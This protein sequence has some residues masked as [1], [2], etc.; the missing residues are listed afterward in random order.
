M[1]V[2]RSELVQYNI[3]EDCFFARRTGEGEPISRDQFFINNP[4]RLM[5]GMFDAIGND[6]AGW[7]LEQYN[8]VNWKV[9]EVDPNYALIVTQ[10]GL[11]ALTDINRGGI[12][13]YFSGLKIINNTVLDP[14]NPIVS[15]TDNDFLQAGQVVFSVGTAGSP[16]QYDDNNNPYLNQ[17]LKWRFSSAS[18]GLQYIVTLPSEG[19][20]AIA[21]DGSE[22]WNI[23][24]IGLYVKDPTDNTS[25]VLFAVA[26][27]PNVVTKYATTVT[28]VGNAIKLYFNT[29]LSNLGI[30]TNLQVLQE[31]EQNIPEVPNESL[32]TYPSDPKQRMYNCYVVD[33]LYGTGIPGLAIPRTVTPQIVTDENPEDLHAYNSNLDWAF[34][35]PSDNFILLENDNFENNVQNYSFVYWNA[36]TQKYGLAE[37][38]DVGDAPGTNTKM[39]I[40][41]RVGNSVVFSG[42]IINKSQSYQYSLELAAGGENYE[43]YDE[44]LILANDGLNFKVR[45]TAVNEVGAIV[46][47]S[48][49]GPAVGNINVEGSPITLMGVYDPRSQLPRLGSGARFI[50]TCIPQATLAWDYDSTWLN[51]PLYCDQGTNAG[52]ATLTK[53]DSFLGWC[54]GANSIRLALDLRNEASTAVYGTTRYAT[55]AEVKEVITNANASEQT[56]VTPKTLN[57][58][59]LQKTLPTNRNQAGSS[60]GNPINVESYVRFDKVVLGRGAKAP[61][62]NTT[63]NPYVTDS[64]ISFYGTA[65]RA[66]W[67]D[68]AEFYESDKW[69][70]PG[71]LITFGKG[72]AEITIATVECNGIISSK[73]GYQLGEKKSELSLP[74]ALTGRVPVLFDANCM[75]KFGDKIYL[76]KIRKGCAST[77]P[78]GK[79]LGKIIEK[80]PGTS[81]LIECVVR[82]EF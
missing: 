38:R 36:S 35:T 51:K 11:T 37:G 46:N 25:D 57:D 44:L 34:F 64:N 29:I 9:V 1:L 49:V 71:T 67:A 10:A 69:Y 23:G 65:F 32:L 60:L 30:A 5:A 72:T 45:I 31:G 55:N 48:F 81:K 63:T 12:K 74:V 53:T 6:S 66:W 28:R 82:I 62:D 52:K 73:P 19:F 54:T 33:S 7:E 80:N 27:L 47:Y 17:I 79:C 21:D 76:S 24:A 42:E 13:L 14:S 15:W 56:T 61:Y 70:E 59:Y 50:V 26:S 3:A 20:G 2:P 75:P 18:G 16:N 68:L 40:G 43:I 77:V 41:I 58:N 8:G 78:Y 39:P 4:T 22:Q